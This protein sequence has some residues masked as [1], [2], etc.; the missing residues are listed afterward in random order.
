MKRNKSLAFAALM[1]VAAAVFTVSCSKK[2]MQ[3]EP[4]QTPAP[5][6]EQTVVTPTDAKPADAKPMEESRTDRSSSTAIASDAVEQTAFIDKKIYFEF[7]S[8]ML[9]SQAREILIRQADYLRSNIDV[10]LT[11]EGHCDERGTEAYNMALG[12]RQ[13]DS[14]KNFLVD[15]GIPT[16]RLTTISYGEERPAVMGRNE[17][18][19]A[20][21]R[22]VQYQK[23]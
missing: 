23:H 2:T 5:Q 8:D 20:Q 7:D 17:S 16:D 19:W 21:N 13:A 12:Q 22:R 15:M 9:S 3:T 6:A 11:L 1:I 10:R 18:A 14:V 4:S